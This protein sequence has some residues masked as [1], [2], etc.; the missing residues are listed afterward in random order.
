MYFVYLVVHNPPWQHQG[1]QH[2]DTLMRVFVDVC[3]LHDL[4][5]LTP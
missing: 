4:H 5:E 1:E 2:R 3:Q